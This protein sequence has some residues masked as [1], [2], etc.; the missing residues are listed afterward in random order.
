MSTSVKSDSGSR[1]EPACSKMSK[2]DRNWY[3]V[4]AA[5]LEIATDKTVDHD[6]RFVGGAFKDKGLRQQD[7]VA[8]LKFRS[9]TAVDA[10]ETGLF[11]IVQSEGVA[12]VLVPRGR[13]RDDADKR[14]LEAAVLAAGGVWW[15]PPSPGK[16]DAV[17]YVLA[18]LEVTN[19]ATYRCC[20]DG[21]GNWRVTGLTA[22]E[23]IVLLKSQEDSD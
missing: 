16:G 15:L 10:D 17:P 1:N 14:A 23:A 20:R 18:G 5:L 6:M 13:W 7:I 11:E 12:L 8:V 3:Q 4:V 9:F 2:R 21:D 19:Y 22:D